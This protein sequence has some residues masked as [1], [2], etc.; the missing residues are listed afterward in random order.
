M[1]TMYHWTEIDINFDKCRNP[2]MLD[3]N[4]ITEFI[5]SP[6]IPSDKFLHIANHIMMDDI[7]KY[8][9]LHSYG[10]EYL[11][12]ELLEYVI[13]D[14]QRSEKWIEYH[15]EFTKGKAKIEGDKFSMIRGAIGEMII[16]DNCN[17]NEICNEKVNKC[18]IGFIKEGNNLCAPDLLL[19]NSNQEIIPV[20]IKCLP[21][22]VCFDINNKAFHREFKLA[23]KQ[24]NYISEIINNIYKKKV[25]KGIIIFAYFSQ[26][27]IKTFYIIVD[28]I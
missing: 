3:D 6:I 11:P 10:I 27:Y 16:T 14:S 19:I 23:R 24:I 22:E 15:R 20:E 28:I 5:K 21:M 8:F 7:N 2:T 1:L 13:Y 26:V 18:M 4:I 25:K 9:I 17:F 12:Q